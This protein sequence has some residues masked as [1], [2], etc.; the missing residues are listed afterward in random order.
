[1]AFLLT[2]TAFLS[3]SIVWPSSLLSC[4]IHCL[5]KWRTACSAHFR[6]PM[7]SEHSL[8][9][10]PLGHCRCYRHLVAGHWGVNV[11]L[12]LYRDLPSNRPRPVSFCPLLP[13]CVYSSPPHLLRPVASAPPI[14]I[15][16][17][18]YG[19][20]KVGAHTETI[21]PHSHL[22]GARWN[23][24]HTSRTLPSLDICLLSKLIYRHVLVW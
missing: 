6:W 16:R 12:Q 24:L 2:V 10:S 23:A 20:V 14:F 11:L 17:M 9:L 7:R 3:D 22:L 18:F 8:C 13:P 4:G 15:V 1:M 19:D 5:A 21:H